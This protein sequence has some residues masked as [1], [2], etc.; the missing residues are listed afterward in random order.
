MRNPKKWKI[1]YTGNFCEPELREVY[2]KL[3][4]SPVTAV[5]LKNR[6]FDTSE[7]AKRFIEK[8]N[9]LFYDPFKMKDMEKAVD[10]IEK[11]LKNNE[12][13]I[14]YGDYDVDGVTSVSTLYLYLKKHGA[15]IGYY[16]PSRIGEGYGLN[17]SAVKAFSDQGISLIITVDT[18][19]TAFDETE[20]AKSFGIDMIVTD[21]HECHSELPGA[22]AVVNP[23]RPDCEYPFKELAGVGVVFKVICAIEQKLFKG[24]DESFYDVLHRICIEY[25]DLV[26]IGTVADVMPIIEENRLIVSLGLKIIDK[27]P[28]PGLEALLECSSANTDGRPAKTVKRRKVT[29]SLIGYVIAPR[30]NAAGR[31]SNA[32][33]AVEL[34]LNESQQSVKEIAKNLC[35]INRQRQAEENRIIE[36]AYE[37]IEKEHDFKK[38][39]VI[40]L[41]E[42][43]WHHGVIGIVSSRIT[44]H[45]NLPSILISFD[46]DTGKGSGRSIKGLNLVDALRDSS[47]LL[48][49]FGGHELAAGLSIS[50]EKLPEFRRRINEYAA[51]HLTKDDMITALNI[52]C[53]LQ[54]KD[55]TIR[56]VNEM[57]LLEPYGINNQTPEFI[58]RNAVICDAVPIG[59][60][61]HTKYIVKKDGITL[62]AVYFGAELA[63][64]DFYPGDEVDIVFNLDINDYQNMQIVQLIVRDM[65][66]SEKQLSEMEKNRSAYT[67][68]K[69]GRRFKNNANIVPTRE[70]F[71]AVYL[72]LKN[73]IR[74]GNDVKS[75][76]SIECRMKEKGISYTKL[77]FIIDIFNET[78][79]IGAEKLTD[80]EID[81]KTDMYKFKLSFNKNKVNLEKSSI[82][83]ILKSRQEK[84]EKDSD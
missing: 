54:A 74:L 6:G 10:R 27:N 70:D 60:N 69:D 32:S 40:I 48:V 80:D 63:D 28:R 33:D 3:N 78:N 51:S 68:I 29:S 49:K 24:E 42:D 26:A 20:Y 25:A 67:E 57:Y 41:A 53:E 65:N 38:D 58:L 31:I 50:K 81:G 45:Y 59:A 21:H 11:A 9:F 43:S 82:L 56:Q 37:K 55:L 34:F 13:I 77:R 22:A 84:E 30:I 7:K 17:Q 2:E 62:T 66:Y 72:Y 76:H 39:S 5:L 18:G 19:I 36:Q 14:I 52:D 73:E 4:I 79:I 1:K 47:D 64:L 44:E 12:K 23:K 16:I 8:D 71:A 61:R 46:G 75:L 35:E 83:K 15:D